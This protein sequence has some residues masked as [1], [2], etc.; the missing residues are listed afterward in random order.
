M[1]ELPTQEQLVLYLRKYGGDKEGVNVKVNVWY[2][3]GRR[4]EFDQ[5]PESIDTSIDKM[6]ASLKLPKD[7]L[8]NLILNCTTKESPFRGITTKHVLNWLDKN[9]K[10]VKVDEFNNIT[11]MWVT[12]T[13]AITLS[14]R[15]DGYTGKYLLPNLLYSTEW[16]EE[17]LATDILDVNSKVASVY[18]TLSSRLWRVKAAAGNR[19][20]LSLRDMLVLRLI[21]LLSK[22]FSD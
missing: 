1:K 6:V 20:S 22:L 5:S 19:A 14:Q 18:N 7:F 17:R 21:S 3:G 16:S 8:I 13:G 9:Y 4:I 11:K 12:D 15:I 2:Y 10:S